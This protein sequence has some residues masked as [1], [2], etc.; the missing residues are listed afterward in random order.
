[1]TK[2]DIEKSLHQLFVLIFRFRF[3]YK[4][5]HYDVNVTKVT[6]GDI[7]EQ[8]S[9]EHFLTVSDSTLYSLNSSILSLSK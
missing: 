8:W 5:F 4:H 3:Q 7:Y 6:F 2:A 9:D 1:M